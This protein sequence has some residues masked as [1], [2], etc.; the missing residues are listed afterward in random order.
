[1]DIQDLNK[2]NTDFQLLTHIVEL[3]PEKR[4]D[5]SKMFGNLDKTSKYTII[6]GV[7]SVLQ[8]KEVIAFAKGAGKAK[9]VSDLVNGVYTNNSPITVLNIHSGK[10]T[11]CSDEEA[12]SLVK[13]YNKKF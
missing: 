1:M 3:T 4:K 7:K 12:G 8:A 6:Q 5:K 2:L 9:A 13:E 11:V 10:V